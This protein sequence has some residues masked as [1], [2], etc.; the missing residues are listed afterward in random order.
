MAYQIAATVA[1]LL[2]LGGA[3]LWGIVGL[4]QDFGTA[5]RGYSELKELYEIGSHIATAKTLLG[6]DQTDLRGALREVRTADGKFRLFN[7]AGHSAE[8]VRKL[9]QSLNDAQDELVAAVAADPPAPPGVGLSLAINQIMGHMSSLAGEVRRDIQAAQD[10]ASAR[11]R[12]TI[13]ALTGLCALVIAGVV[14]SAMAQ[15]RA[16]MRPL[17]RIS[18]T[19]RRFAQGQLSDRVEPVGHAEFTALAADFN[20]MAGELD[21]LYRELERKVAEKSRELVRSERLASV[22]FLAAGVAHEINNPIGIIAGYAELSQQQLDRDAS[23]AAVEEARKTLGVISDEAFRCKQIVQKLLS[24]ARPGEDNRT[25]LSLGDVARDVVATVGGLGQYHDRRLVL[26]VPAGDDLGVI[27]SEGEMKQ[28]L[29]N[30]TLNALEALDGDGGEVR[31]SAKRKDAMVELIVEDNGRGMTADV[32]ERI[33]EP[34][35]T[36]RRGA[37]RPGTGLGLS[38]SNAIIQSHGGTIS[39]HSD[40]AGRGSRFVVQLPAAGG[41]AA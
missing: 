9:R 37:G 10:A 25:R 40:G 31:I 6:R 17:Q 35:Y 26:D 7:P 16:V 38:I 27:A 29:L 11:R 19:V 24:L 28:V 36:A 41:G 20:R 12:T 2:L 8:V 22:G 23:P 39:A 30:L 32:L 3:S 15:Y 4:H 14:V 5:I 33:F 34:F 1:A 18:S 13:I 21:T